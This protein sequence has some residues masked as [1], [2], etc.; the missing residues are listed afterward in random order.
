MATLTVNIAADTVANDGKLSLREAVA[1]ANATAGADTI[2]FASGLEGKTLT[3]TGGELVLTR[4]L[5][6]D[7]DS[8]NDG[9]EVTIS[10][11]GVSRILRITGGN[12][13]VSLRDLGLTAGR[14]PDDQNGGAIH[15]GGRSLRLDDCDVSKSMINSVGH[16]YGGAGIFA[17]RDTELT[18]VHS[19]VREC[20]GNAETAAGSA[21]WAADRSRVSV[22]D[23][24]ISK[25]TAPVYG[26]G[27]IFCGYG[28]TLVIRDSAIVDQLR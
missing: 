9:K 14:A 22:V 26:T 1:Q 27:G 16:Y 3:L 15:S 8:N 5:T 19:T 12:T 7:G 25:N 4:D 17:A 2:R 10:G 13:D 23:S 28:V 21:I 11:G 18:L 20:V 24:E 6:I